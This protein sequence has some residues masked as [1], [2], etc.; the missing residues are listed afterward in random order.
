MEVVEFL[1]CLSVEPISFPAIFIAS[2][3]DVLQAV[4]AMQA[5]AATVPERPYGDEVLLCAVRSALEVDARATTQTAQRTALGTLTPREDEVL[6]GLLEGKTNKVIARDLG[7]S[8]RTVE[9]YRA[10]V[11]KKAG[12]SS[13]PELVWCAVG[14]ERFH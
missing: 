6:S 12:V 14:A 1:R 3:G 7:I 9:V 10:S 13:L 5:G 11:T 4:E 8:P 2:G